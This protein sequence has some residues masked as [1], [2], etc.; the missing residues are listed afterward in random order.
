M[1]FIFSAVVLANT[2]AEELGITNG[3]GLLANEKISRALDYSRAATQILIGV[4]YSLN[5]FAV[6]V[7][8]FDKVLVKYLPSTHGALA[9]LGLLL[10]LVPEDMPVLVVPTNSWVQEPLKDFVESMA[11]DEADIGLLVV[12]S[13][14]PE[15]SYVRYV[16]EKIVEIHEKEVVSEY[17]I[18]GHFYFRNKKVIL[19]C[20]DWA[21]I[22][23][24]NK[25]GL[26]YIAPSL[27]YSI[28]KGMKISS[29][30]ADH[31]KYTHIR[32]AKRATHEN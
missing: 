18:S 29:F 6:G 30:G 8:K 12:K 16:G 20:L 1:T 28:T 31:E 5:H 7:D 25:D 24:I 21:M 11:I 19:N 2:D 9:S 10:D 23:N 14:S 15:L 4:N 27:N 22:N 26:L 13:N 3:A 32:Q 17:A